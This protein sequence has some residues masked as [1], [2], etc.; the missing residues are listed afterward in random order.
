MKLN[1]F[2]EIFFDIIP[3][4]TEALNSPW[5]SFYNCHEQL[6]HI[7]AL[8]VKVLVIQTLSAVALIYCDQSVDSYCYSAAVSFPANLTFI[9][10]WAHGFTSLSVTL[11]SRQDT[12]YL[13]TAYT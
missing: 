8:L 6:H 2:T 11:G 13:S 3:Q 5:H 12:L 10:F 9:A 7:T 4:N 1:Y